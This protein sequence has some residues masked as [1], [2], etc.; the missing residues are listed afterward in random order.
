MKKANILIIED[1]KDH[2]YFIK[3]GLGT[4]KYTLNIITD[5]LEAYQYLLNPKIVPNI[6]LLDQYLPNM[7]GFEILEKLGNKKNDY[8]IIF[9]SVDNAALTIE[10]ALKYGAI[11]FIVK[12]HDFETVISKKIKKSAE[13]FKQKP[14]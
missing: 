13:V 11:D 6:V 5:G 9:I 8:H 1:N 2:L 10:K 12:N 3:K 4:E 14:Q 7:G